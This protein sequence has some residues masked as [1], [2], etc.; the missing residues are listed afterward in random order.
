MTLSGDQAL[1]TAVRDADSP[2]WSV[3]AA[4]GRRLAAS[5]KVDEM[6]D[7]IHRLLLD[8]QDTAVTQETAVALLARR[9][10]IG[11]RRVLLA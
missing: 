10:S 9:D 1:T 11:L 5:D 6:A 4:A 7:V 3:R 8:A 2:D